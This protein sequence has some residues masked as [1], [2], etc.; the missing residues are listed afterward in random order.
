[1]ARRG[2]T[3]QR[4]LSTVTPP[5]RRMDSYMLYATSAVGALFMEGRKRWSVILFIVR[6]T[7]FRE[8]L[9]RCVWEAEGGADARAG[10]RATAPPSSPRCLSATTPPPRAAAIHGDPCQEP[11]HGRTDDV[12]T[13]R[14][15]LIFITP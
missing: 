10:G 8:Q 6:T 13:R 2:V 3:A 15:S 12:Y 4:A 7:C 5:Q 9:P 11:E 14:R 1:M